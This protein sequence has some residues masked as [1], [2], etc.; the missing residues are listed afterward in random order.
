MTKQQADGHARH[1]GSSQ[2]ALLG[3]ESEKTHTACF[4][5]FAGRRILKISAG[6]GADRSQRAARLAALRLRRVLRPRQ[7]GFQGLRLGFD[8]RFGLPQLGQRGCFFGALGLGD[9]FGL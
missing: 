2:H 4:I 6:S 1:D 9:R 3:T 8:V 7:L 5:R